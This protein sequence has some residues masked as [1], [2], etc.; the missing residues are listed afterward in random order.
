V[1]A[2]DLADADQQGG[3]SSGSAP[4]AASSTTCVPSTA[5]T[6][7]DDCRP[8]IGSRPSLVRSCP[9]LRSCSA[10]RSMIGRLVSVCTSVRKACLPSCGA[11]STRIV[12]VDTPDGR[13]T[14]GG[15]I[16]SR[17]WRGTRPAA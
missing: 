5:L 17:A 9:A 3:G 4:T 11:V 8:R 7:S 14:L 6:V 15:V 2:I 16:C 13:T 10:T 1:L 12:P